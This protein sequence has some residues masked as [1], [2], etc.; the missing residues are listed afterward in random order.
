MKDQTHAS[1]TLAELQL[2]DWIQSGIQ[3][4]EAIATELIPDEGE[5]E[6]TAE[7]IEALVEG[8]AALVPLTRQLRFM[9][10]DPSGHPCMTRVEVMN[11]A[12]PMPKRGPFGFFAKRKGTLV[13][14]D[15]QTAIVDM[16]Y[17][18]AITFTREGVGG[19]A[20]GGRWVADGESGGP[21]D[22]RYHLIIVPDEDEAPV[23]AA[24]ESL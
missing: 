20:Y 22:A 10:A 21:A 17:G 13:A 3:K 7:A 18:K 1:D 14:L 15:H 11:A 23:M 8:F 6:D 24:F 5:L 16:D 12:E 9:I 4:A 19:L 2:L